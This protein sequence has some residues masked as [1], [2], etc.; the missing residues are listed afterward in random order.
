MNQPNQYATPQRLAIK[1]RRQLLRDANRC[2]NG[3]LEDRPGQRGVLHGSPGK[4][5]RCDRCNEIHGRSATN[6]NN[7]AQHGESNNA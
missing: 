5:G 1:T 7:R 2:I 3:P 6:R 4:G